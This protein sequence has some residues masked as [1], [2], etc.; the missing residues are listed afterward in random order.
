MNL[1]MLQPFKLPPPHQSFL[2][3]GYTLILLLVLYYSFV[4]YCSV[5]CHFFC[6]PSLELHCSQLL[7]L[8]FQAQ[9]SATMRRINSGKTQLFFCT[10]FLFIWYYIS[11][12]SVI[13]CANSISCLI[14]IYIRSYV[15]LLFYNINST[16]FIVE[17]NVIT[18]YIWFL[19]HFLK[20]TNL[21]IIYA[22]NLQRFAFQ[23]F[24]KY[25]GI[26]RPVQYYF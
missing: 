19:V 9:N 18:D 1:I 12:F 16:I 20:G 22:K 4:G 25:D 3:V 8:S 24:S 2:W 13:Y 10:F 6:V 17:L 14:L 23:W 7:W 21:C 5:A 11:I 15:Y 26:I